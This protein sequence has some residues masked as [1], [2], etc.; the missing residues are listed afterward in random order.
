MNPSGT[1]SSNLQGQDR[2]FLSSSRGRNSAQSI[3]A[4][5][6]K[7]PLSTSTFLNFLTFTTSPLW[8]LSH[9]LITVWVRVVSK[10]PPQWR[11]LESGGQPSICVSKVRLRCRM[12]SFS[13]RWLQSEQD[14]SVDPVDD[15]ERYGKTWINRGPGILPGCVT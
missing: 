12:L 10:T 6:T 7:I 15:A 11:G 4:R 2:N 13:K 14:D 3:D 8:P 9:P 1:E 5:T